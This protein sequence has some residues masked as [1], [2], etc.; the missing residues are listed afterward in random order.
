MSSSTLQ[1]P[2]K[3]PAE[4][5]KKKQKPKIRRFRIGVAVTIQVFAV[6]TLIGMVNYLS[7]RHF[8]RYDFSI[9]RRFTLSERT[10]KLL[11]SLTHPV[12]IILYMNDNSI[13]RSDITDLLKQY[14]DAAPNLFTIEQLSV[15]RDIGRANE[16][17]AK[18]KLG[19]DDNAIII[20]Y[21]GHTSIVTEDALAD[22]D[23]GGEMLGQPAQITSFK[24]E[25]AI[26]GALL[27]VIEG[28]KN[29]VYYLTGQAEPTLGEQGGIHAFQ[30]YI[31]RDN[32][33][34]KEVNLRNVETVPPDA[35]AIC[36]LGQKYDL[37]ESEVKQ[38][39][40]YWNKKGRILLLLNPD[41]E[42]PHLNQFLSKLGIEPDNDRL[43][44]VLTLGTTKE[45]AQIV[46]RAPQLDAEVVP[47]AT[48]SIVKTFKNV[49]L[50]FPG[51]VQSLTLNKTQL[52][53][54]DIRLLP[55]LQAQKGF[56]GEGGY[57]NTEHTNT[58]P[59]PGQDKTSNL[60][61]AVSVE[62]DV[63]TDQRNQTG[64]SR[65]VVFATS[66][67]VEDSTLDQNKADLLVNAFQWL[68]NREQYIGIPPKEVKSFTLDLSSGEL[69]SIFIITTFAIPACVAFLGLIVW[70]RRRS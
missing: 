12:K 64:T 30:S 41:A 44:K 16:L 50:V 10:T 25:Q 33:Q 46:M 13:V 3:T 5:L 36:I 48:S 61:F 2:K 9:D 8:K 47:G 55:L 37:T 59:I 31:E 6:V 26:T 19:K 67:F 42:T 35:N 69:H 23:R 34:F 65:M 56:W 68:L 21:N 32:I 66:R 57:K 4:F 28:K 40:A 53:G 70:W 15:Y 39:E 24:G 38:L 52:K 58:R 18:Y 43:T 49:N 7:S 60:F 29:I 54:F 22:V 17:Q 63:K 45:G 27:E 14:Q 1:L 62:G 20:E 11:K 51:A